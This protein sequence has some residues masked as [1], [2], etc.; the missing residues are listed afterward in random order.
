MRRVKA[1][2]EWHPA[3]DQ[4]LGTDVYGTPSSAA[5]DETFSVEFGA[6]DQFLFATGDGAKWVIVDKEQVR[7][8]SSGLARRVAW[9]NRVLSH[10]AHPSLWHT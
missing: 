2:T 9:V 7:H 4:L 6:F 5:A 10:G 8:G 1:G 3:T